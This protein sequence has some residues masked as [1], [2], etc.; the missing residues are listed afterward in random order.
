MNLLDP[1]KRPW[2]CIRLFV[3]GRLTEE[4]LFAGP[5]CIWVLHHAS[6]WFVIARDKTMHLGD[7]CTFETFS[8]FGLLGEDDGLTINEKAL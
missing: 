1:S 8:V 7:G 6:G 4:M 2:R 3:D 5:S